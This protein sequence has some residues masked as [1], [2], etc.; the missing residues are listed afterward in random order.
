[1]KIFKILLLVAILK[2]KQNI[3]KSNIHERKCIFSKYALMQHF[4]MLQA[5]LQTATKN[6]K[7]N[8]L[9]QRKALSI[10]LDQ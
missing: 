7:L 9:I 10:K 5:V 2:R 4:K 8:D 6:L 3:N 1:M